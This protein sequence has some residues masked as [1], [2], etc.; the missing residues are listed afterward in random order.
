MR[1]LSLH[2]ACDGGDQE[3]GPAAEAPGLDDGKAAA[4]SPAPQRSRD[5][6][7]WWITLGVDH[8]IRRAGAM[9]Q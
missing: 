4:A 6:A 3:T 1:Y 2:E 9:A 8:D 5:T 7:A